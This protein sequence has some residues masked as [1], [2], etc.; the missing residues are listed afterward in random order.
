M[1]HQF[2]CKYSVCVE[3][4]LYVDAGTQRKLSP[5]LPRKQLKE[6]VENTFHFIRILSQVQ[7]GG[8]NYP[9]RKKPLFSA[10]TFHLEKVC[11]KTILK[12]KR[13]LQINKDA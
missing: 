12:F 1:L 11:T 5:Q 4:M 8:E 6:Q 7:G 3:C 13:V 9:T 2:W 10:P